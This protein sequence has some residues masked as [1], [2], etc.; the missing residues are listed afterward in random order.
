MTFPVLLTAVLVLALAG[1]SQPDRPRASAA[2]VQ[3]CRMEV[4]RVYSAQNRVDLSLRDT[5][6]TPFASNYNSGITSRGLGAQFGRDNQTQSCI[7]EATNGSAS[8]ASSAASTGPTFETTPTS[9]S[10]S[11][12]SK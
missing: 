12:A 7:N 9:A 5:R 8:A 10:K 6:D 3:K 11:N 2:V 1:C 4:D